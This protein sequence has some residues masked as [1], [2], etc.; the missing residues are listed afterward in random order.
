VKKLIGISMIL[1]IDV[2]SSNATAQT[3]VSRASEAPVNLHERPLDAESIAR[4]F[5]E[6]SRNKRVQGIERESAREQKRMGAGARTLIIAGAAVGGFFGGGAL[7][8]KLENT[9]APCGCD[10]PGLKGAL[11]GAPIGAIAGGVIAAILTR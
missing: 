8:H 2:A 7:G 10:D 6:W 9:F 3:T 11:I 5:D 4:H 1:F